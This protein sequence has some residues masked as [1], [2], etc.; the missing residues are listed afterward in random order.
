MLEPIHNTLRDLEAKIEHTC[1]DQPLLLQNILLLPTYTYW[2]IFTV[3]ALYLFVFGIITI[4]WLIRYTSSSALHM[5]LFQVLAIV[6]YAITDKAWA[7][8]W[9]MGVM[10]GGS[11]YNSLRE[12][13]FVKTAELAAAGVVAHEAPDLA[14]EV[15]KLS[16]KGCVRIVM[17]VVGVVVRGICWYVLDLGD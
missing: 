3:V 1:I 6:A 17:G 2:T 15:I 12:I 7:W 13:G 16:F 11:I 5:D 14:W 8:D 4:D 9:R 10:A